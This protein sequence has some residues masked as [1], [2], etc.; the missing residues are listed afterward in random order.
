M[1]F[2]NILLILPPFVVNMIKIRVRILVVVSDLRI[3][4]KSSQFE[5]G[6][7]LRAEVSSP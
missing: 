4:S 7:Y 6:C 1:F 5:S 3:E 2:F